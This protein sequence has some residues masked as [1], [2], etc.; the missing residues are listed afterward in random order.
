MGEAGADLHSHELIGVIELILAT[1]T[2]PVYLV[3]RM[4]SETRTNA[5]CEAAEAPQ[6]ACARIVEAFVCK[7]VESLPI[8]GLEC[9]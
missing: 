2:S 3:H 8:P 4:A 5:S 1:W 9:P 7:L 6:N